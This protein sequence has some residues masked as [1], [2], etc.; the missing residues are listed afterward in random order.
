MARLHLVK[1]ILG[2][3]GPG[4]SEMR[5]VD[6]IPAPGTLLV[7]TQCSLPREDHQ[8][9]AG[10]I[11]VEA[12]SEHGLVRSL[13]RVA[14][15]VVLVS[16]FVRGQKQVGH[17]VVEERLVVVRGERGAAQAPQC[18]HPRASRREGPQIHL[19]GHRQV[20]LSLGLHIRLEGGGRPAER[21]EVVC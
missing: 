8:Y 5:K 10:A 13:A 17:F 20:C 14:H 6:W 2:R 9:R 11:L 21:M 7:K 4:K 16:G 3:R 18:P 15:L 12:E 19:Q 1:Y